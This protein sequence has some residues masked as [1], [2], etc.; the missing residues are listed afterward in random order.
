M[1]YLAT[2]NLAGDDFANR[3]KEP[4]GLGEPEPGC[5]PWRVWNAGLNVSIVTIRRDAV[6][7]RPG[8]VLL[9]PHHERLVLSEVDLDE[10]NAISVGCATDR[11]ARN[12]APRF[13]QSHAQP[14]VTH[15]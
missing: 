1:T 5:I 13:T 10:G 8:V 11:R 14:D 2:F 12:C 6:D 3:T 9:G 7:R 15:G 4:G